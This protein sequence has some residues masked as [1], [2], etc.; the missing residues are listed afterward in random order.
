[1]IAA[2]L[3]GRKGSAGFPGKNTYPVLGRPMASYPMMAAKGA[4]LVDRTYISTDDDQLM[5][6]G[7][8]HGLEI[9]VRPP[10]LATKAALGEELIGSRIVSD[11]NLEAHRCHAVDRFRN[12]FVLVDW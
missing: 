11:Q 6:L 7:R 10:H 12:G 3:L 2:L 8:E 9:I 1:M 4:K 5:A